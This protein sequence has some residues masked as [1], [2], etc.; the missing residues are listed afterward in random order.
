MYLLNYFKYRF[1]ALST[2]HHYINITTIW[3]QNSFHL[4]ELKVNFIVFHLFI[5]NLRT[6]LGLWKNEDNT[7]DTH[8][9]LT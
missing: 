3:P 9:P 5:F 2:S 4:A 7:E 8:I 1:K 6:V